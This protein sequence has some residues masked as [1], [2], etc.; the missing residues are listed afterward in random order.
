[1]PRQLAA[2]LALVLSVGVAQAQAPAA[3]HSAAGPRRD[4]TGTVREG[5]SGAPA[6]GAIVEARDGLS[7]EATPW[8]QPTGLIRATA[9]VQGRFTL[10][11][12][13]PGTYTV[14]AVA[15][16]AGR[17]RRHA[18]ASGAR[19]E[20]LLVPA[21]SAAGVVLGPDGA[22]SA[23]ALV[24]IESTTGT[25]I[26]GDGL[27]V[28][29]ATGHFELFGL[30]AG[31]YRVMARQKALAPAWR[32]ISVDRQETADASLRLGPSLAVIGRVV[33][34][35][36]RALRGHVSVA[37]VDGA[38]PPA[39]LAT[40][41]QADTAA[42]GTFRLGPVPAGVVALTIRGARSGSHR[43]DVPGAAPGHTVVDL[44]TLALDG[45]DAIRGVVQDHRGRSVRNVRVIAQEAAQPVAQAVSAVAAED[46]TSADGSFVIAGLVA[47]RYRIAV[48][49]PGLGTADREAQRGDAGVVLVIQENGR[50]TGRVSDAAGAP[51]DGYRLLVRPQPALRNGGSRGTR[52][53][54]EAA[55]AAFSLAVQPATYLIDIM[56]P[57]REP[58]SVP[59]VVVEAGRT[60][61]LGEVRLG[62]GGV[63]RGTVVDTTGAPVAGAVVTAAPDRR[64][65]V[66]SE[67]ASDASGAFELRGVTF[68]PVRLTARHPAF[69]EGTAMADVDTDRPAAAR[70]VLSAGGRL[71]G[72]ARHRDGSA[73]LGSIAVMPVAVGTGAFASPLN[74]PIDPDGTF[75]VDR[76]PA[77]PAR[78]L[79]LLGTTAQLP[80]G[81][82]RDVE[83]REGQTASASF[84]LR[85]I[86][87][88]GRITRAGT[89]AGG[90]RVTLAE[91]APAGGGGIAPLLL[92]GPSSSAGRGMAVTRDDGSYELIT[93]RPGPTRV[94][95]DAADGSLRIPER[96]VEIPD[97]EQTSL[98][99]DF[100][101]L[102]LTGTVVDSET[103]RP[104]A[105][106]S[107]VADAKRRSQD[108]QLA[109]GTTDAEGRFQLAVEPGEYRVQAEAGEYLGAGADVEVGEAGAPDVRLALVRGGL[110]RGRVTDAQ[111]RPATG[112]IVRAIS[113]APG[114]GMVATPILPDGRFEL[115]G[116]EEAEHTLVARSDSGGY[117]LRAGIRS[118]T[119]AVTLVTARGG[120]IQVRIVRP[121]GRPAA[122]V[123]ATV[124]RVG[125]VSAVG[126][127]PSAVSDTRGVAEVMSPP[128]MVEVSVNQLDGE[129]TVAS[130]SA[131]VMVAAGGTAFAD[132]SLVE[133]PVSR[134]HQ[135]EGMT[136]KEP[137]ISEPPAAPDDTVSLHGPSGH[138]P[139]LVQQRAG[140]RP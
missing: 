18:V 57:D 130:G 32:T 5:R 80:S 92:A 95:V 82:A 107:V 91:A 9:D 26:P 67:T 22:P 24:R 45:G 41:L 3:S 59:N 39:A 12:L 124:L 43:V 19:I 105:R 75:T 54:V 137:A 121:D 49:A 126:V 10:S 74:A 40:L 125:G 138:H 52:R 50:V 97:V 120:R 64:P 63:V 133:A 71:R 25:G 123:N 38:A 27:V 106:A 21:G 129:A 127:T 35:E 15:R 85:D 44:G 31:R 58:V 28:A 102:V 112:G 11:G 14:S 61:D 7:R 53:E 115:R 62:T 72:Q 70:I 66:S 68:G 89:P 132:V 93:D 136:T 98:D 114:A 13:G 108:A 109:T 113:A 128:G 83:V 48:D 81:Q 16:G 101:S 116:L 99:L 119:E 76:V 46:T 90:F 104:L 134:S 55:D 65:R 37:D 87:V 73:V 78:V 122:G 140:G 4:I 139:V 88:G 131:S 135:R 69:A 30:E 110:V 60:V 34:A 111:G 6:A 47:E 118:G 20:L 117:A 23:G 79:L 17:A 36:H 96:L 1:M 2:A 51:V 33:D 77:G 84:E 42:D 103:Q 56:A 94:T 100:P 29:D 86:H 8:D